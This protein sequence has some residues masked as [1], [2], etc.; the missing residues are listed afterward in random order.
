MEPV[1]GSEGFRKLE[2]VYAV[3]PE[4][5]VA[6]AAGGGERMAEPGDP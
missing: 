3:E 4:L 6:A 5:E 2:E 1:G